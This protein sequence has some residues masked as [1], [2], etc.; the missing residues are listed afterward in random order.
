MDPA[1][2]KEAP[3][4][5]SPL[6]DQVSGPP[7][8]LVGAYPFAALGLSPEDAVDCWGN[9]FTYAVTTSLTAETTYAIAGNLGG[10]TMRTGML[11]SA[12]DLT[13]QAA[14]VIVSHGAQSDGASSRTYSGTKK[15]CN[16]MVSNASV[17]RIDKENCDT[18]NRTFFYQPYN[19]GD[20]PAQFFD[21]LVVY[22]T[23]APLEVAPPGGSCGP[24][25]VTWGGNCA[26]PALITLLGLSV[27]L[28]NINSG[29]TGLAISTC[30]NGERQTIGTC[31]PIG[32]CSAASPRGGPLVLLTGVS[33]NFG[34]GIC[35][36]YSCCSGSIQTSG[37]FPCPALDLPG[38][39]HCS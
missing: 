7:D 17:L 5:T 3:T 22:A 31:L 33:M 19:N 15:N 26:A 27:N 35:Q 18:L 4:P 13:T 38:V 12:T 11:A 8:V 10:I 39:S 14:Y 1:Y 37:L 6:I 24:G 21:D 9:K 29:Y 30:V 32:T 36:R 20:N 23:K 25:M 2:G 34:T 16:S 28:T